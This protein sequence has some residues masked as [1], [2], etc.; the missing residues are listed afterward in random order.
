MQKT[1]LFEIFLAEAAIYLL[2]WLSNT[3]LATLLSLIFGCIAFIILLIS[4]LVELVERSKVPSW[5][6]SL[7]VASVLAPVAAALIFY[8]LGNELSWPVFL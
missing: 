3:Y 2:L 4:L 1:L 5:Y 6:Y 7:M 8:L